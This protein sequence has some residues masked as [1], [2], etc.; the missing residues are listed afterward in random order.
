MDT[1][2]EGVPAVLV[3]EGS[4]LV[5]MAIEDELNKRGFATVGCARIALAED[6]ARQQQF[7]AALVN[8]HLSDGMPTDFVLALEKS[9]CAVALVSGVD[10]EGVPPPLAH[11]PLFGKP[12]EQG[13]LAN[14]V[15]SQLSATG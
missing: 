9:G 8:L 14:W 15:A 2:P 10:A 7:S 13:K 5:G 1:G 4:I 12:V 6:C 3:L 11:L